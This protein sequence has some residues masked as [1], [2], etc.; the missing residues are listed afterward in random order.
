MNPSARMFVMLLTLLACRS[1]M[2]SDIVVIGRL[3]TNEPMSYV[4]DECPDDHICLHSWWKSV[5]QVPRDAPT[6]FQCSADGGEEIRCGVSA[7]PQPR[8]L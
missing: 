4:K 2:A 7:R 6:I 3:V 8:K 1:A 5:I